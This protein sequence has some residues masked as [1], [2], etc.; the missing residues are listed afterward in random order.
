[1]PSH[2]LGHLPFVESQI[3][4]SICIDS[5]VIPASDAGGV[6]ESHMMKLFEKFDISMKTQLEQLR[7]AQVTHLQL[8]MYTPRARLYRRLCLPTG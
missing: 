1:M 5:V 7:E 4:F 3:S 6:V 8:G 2:A